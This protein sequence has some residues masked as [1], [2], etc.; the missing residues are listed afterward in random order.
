MAK[1]Q[2]FDDEVTKRSRLSQIYET[3]LD[4]LGFNYVTTKDGFTNL[5]AQFTVMIPKNDNREK[6]IKYLNLNSIPTA[7]H[8]PKALQQY[9]PY[10]QFSSDDL[11]NSVMAASQVLSLP[12]HPYL[13]EQEISHLFFTLSG[14]NPNAT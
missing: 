10:I 2:V 8:Y 7:V 4:A 12:F 13:T 1:L 9:S 5:R 6:I 14:Y 11:S 3:R